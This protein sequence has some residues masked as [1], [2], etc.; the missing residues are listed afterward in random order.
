MYVFVPLPI[1]R[2]LTEL[3]KMANW[4]C[5]RATIVMV[6]ISEIGPPG[7]L[8]TKASFSSFRAIRSVILGEGQAVRGRVED[9]T[10][11]MEDRQNHE[12]QK[13]CDES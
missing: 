4:G 3:V 7:R 11:K 5:T 10:R 2:T 12:R 8:A 1:K 6:L 9:P 13:S